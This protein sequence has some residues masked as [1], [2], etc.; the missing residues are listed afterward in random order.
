M[1]E[2]SLEAGEGGTCGS[3]SGCGTVLGM[4]VAGSDGGVP[5]VAGS[6]GRVLGVEVVKVC[7]S[8]CMNRGFMSSKCDST[9]KSLLSMISIADSNRSI[10]FSRSSPSV[11]SGMGSSS[12][13]M[14]ITC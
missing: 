5:G 4:G 3:M 10:L 11:H 14:E 9:V 7:G 13:V 12:T 6:E 1:A 8:A 2:S